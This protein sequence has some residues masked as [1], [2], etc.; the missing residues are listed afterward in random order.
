[1]A[2]NTAVLLAINITVGG[3][4]ADKPLHVIGCCRDCCW[5]LHK[6]LNYSLCFK[7]HVIGFQMV[8]RSNRLLI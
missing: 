4:Y 3:N 8:V 7:F 5:R 6:P 2:T 1:M